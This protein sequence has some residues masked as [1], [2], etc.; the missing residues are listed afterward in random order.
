MQCHKVFQQLGQESK[1]KSESE[2]NTSIPEFGSTDIPV[3]EV[4]LFSQVDWA[5]GSDREQQYVYHEESDI[6]NHNDDDYNRL[7][8]DEIS[9]CL[10]Q[11]SIRFFMNIQT[12]Q[13][14][15]LQNK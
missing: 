2:R 7:T 12:K 6:D 8:M 4:N 11:I 3:L 13:L 14:R 10:K 9:K 5:E 1:R 15:L